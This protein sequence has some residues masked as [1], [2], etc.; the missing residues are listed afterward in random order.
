MVVTATVPGVKEEEEDKE[1]EEEE[2]EEEGLTVDVEL[3]GVLPQHPKEGAPGGGPGVGG[4]APYHPGDGNAEGVQGEHVAQE[5]DD[6]LQGPAQA[7]LPLG[8]QHAG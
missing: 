8:P 2:V 3:V 6:V 7:R 4:V 1:E 5:V